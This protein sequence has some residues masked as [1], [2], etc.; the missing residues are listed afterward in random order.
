M[1]SACGGL[2]ARARILL[3][4]AP[5]VPV[6]ERTLTYSI[7]VQKFR[8]GKEYQ[9]PF[10]LPRE[11]VFEADY[12]IQIQVRTPQA[13]HLYIYNEGPPEGSAPA[14]LVVLFPT[15]TANKQSSFLAANQ[16]VQIPE[17]SR[18]TF[19][20]D[21]GTETVWLIFSADSIPE[22]E[23][24]GAADPSTQGQ[25]TDPAR[26]KVI[27]DFLAKHSTQKP[28]VDKDDKQTILKSTGKLLIH[29]IKLEHY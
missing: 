27:Q 12:R 23:A 3:A 7:T 6:E 8:D 26:N 25:I 11:M 16:V 13:G 21:Q 10:T 19:D 24:I 1:V 28:S 4:V 15:K 18:F 5:P 29:A 9:N 22:L 20:K 2:R 17:E 14:E